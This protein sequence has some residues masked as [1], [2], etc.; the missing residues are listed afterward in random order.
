VLKRETTIGLNGQAINLNAYRD[1]AI[2]IS[3]RFMR[4]SSVFLSN[5]RQDGRA[6]A[7]QDDDEEGMNAEQ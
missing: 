5:I 2:G 7:S 3:R 4:L 6:E 1:M